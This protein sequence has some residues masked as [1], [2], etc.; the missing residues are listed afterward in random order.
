MK[1]KEEPK[2]PALPI[3]SVEV[4]TFMRKPMCPWCQEKGVHRWLVEVEHK[5]LT[6]PA[7]APPLADWVCDHCDFSVS[8]PPGVFPSF[9]H[10]EVHLEESMGIRR[11]GEN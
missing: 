3:G 4:R 7:T 2:K 1:K 11:S 9:E 6:G 10:R 8:L 5:I